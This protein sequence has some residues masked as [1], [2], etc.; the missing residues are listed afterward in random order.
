MQA[1]TRVIVRMYSKTSELMLR[2]GVW[3]YYLDRIRLFS[4]GN[5][6]PLLY[7]HPIRFVLMAPKIRNFSEISEFLPKNFLLENLFSRTLA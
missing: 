4:F 5:Q 1:I 3:I 7:Q 2:V 6:N